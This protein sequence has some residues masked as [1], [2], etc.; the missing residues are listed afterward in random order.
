MPKRR[1]SKKKTEA[2]KRQAYLD[3]QAHYNQSPKGK[4]R[5]KRYE[6]KHPERG[7]RLGNPEYGQNWKRKR[8]R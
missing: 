4:A 5:R 7:F 2:E 6:N 1:A 8:A 3:S